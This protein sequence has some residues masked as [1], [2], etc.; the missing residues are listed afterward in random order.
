MD[1]LLRICLAFNCE[2]SDIIEIMRNDRIS[3]LVE[4]EITLRGN[5]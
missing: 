1:V 3:V 2:V 5:E 4:K